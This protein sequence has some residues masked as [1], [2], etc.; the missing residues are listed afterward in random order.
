VAPQKKT[1]ERRITDGE[2]LARRLGHR[3]LLL[4]EPLRWPN[5]AHLQARY[6]AATSEPERRHVALAFERLVREVHAETLRRTGGDTA[7]ATLTAALAELG[8]PGS[9][10]SLLAFFPTYLR[11]SKG[12]LFGQPF[13]LAGFQTAFLREFY[14]R[15]KHGHR[16]YRHGTL[17]LSRG[18]GKTPL[19]AAVGLYE[20]VSRRDAPEIYC[21]AASKEQARI[22]LDFARSF[23]DD[24]ELS[25][26]VQLGSGL[27]CPAT[28]GTMKVIASQGRTQH[29]RMP[30]VALIDEL[31]AFET[32]AERQ[33]Y[34]ALASALHKRE[35]AF[36]LAITT[37]GYDK[38]SLLG[39]VYDS[40][41]EWPQVE[42]LRNG[43]LTIAKDLEN[44]L[45]LYW[46]GAPD[47][48]AIDD[49]AV[50]RAANPASWIKTAEL[51]RQLADP[52]LNENEFRRLNLNQWT[53]AKDAW[54]PAGV[55]AGLRS[56]HTIPQHAD[57]YVGV[58]VGISHDTTAVCWAHVLEDGRILI[59]AK[60]WSADE[61]A[62]AHHYVTGGRIQLEQIEQFIL[63]RLVPQFRVREVAYDPHFFHRSAELLNKHGVTT[64]EYLPASGPMRDAYQAFY[65]YSREGKL[66]HN[67]DKILAAHIDATA[68][69]KT[70]H[71]WKI[72]K[73]K[74]ARIDAT[75]AA[76][77]AVARARHHKTSQPNVFWIEP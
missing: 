6:G 8:R 50:W 31:W 15:D 64:A 53:T 17:G 22:A 44:G 20:L 13:R 7:K 39:Q 14:R 34:I 67:G 38:H 24:G 29:G 77:L 4:G 30:A 60:V 55:W 36:L 32:G 75:V 65:Q 33:T 19:V 71:G 45:L 42:L 25:E 72:H 28:R 74:N 18:S 70:Q 68:A 56:D 62:A 40:A 46:F 16:I 35:D 54:L 12:P 59:R 23:V 41:L 69:T 5:F 49:P 21:A 27:L 57:V 52:G 11:H 2:F 47:G 43:Y 63:E 1:L 73:L 51:K 26:W 66:T 10:S 48:A 9:I 3:A 76:V 61:K 58:D 37:A